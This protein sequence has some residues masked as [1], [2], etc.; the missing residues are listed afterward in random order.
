MKLFFRILKIKVDKTKMIT[1]SGVKKAILDRLC[2]QLEK[3][4]QQINSEY[5]VV[6][7]ADFINFLVR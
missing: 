1:A 3:I 7:N 2:K 6:E 4:G 5:S